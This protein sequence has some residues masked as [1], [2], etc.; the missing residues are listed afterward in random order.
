MSVLYLL[1]TTTLSHVKYQHVHVLRH[2]DAC[3][4][5]E[6]GNLVG[7]STVVVE[8]VMEGW[9]NRLKR[10]KTPEAIAQ[11]SLFLAR[12]VMMLAEFE[13]YPVSVE[14]VLR[15]DTLRKLKLNIGRNDLR[16]A[17]LALELGATVV[18]DNIR[19][20]GRVPGLL[21]VDWTG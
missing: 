12:A 3:T 10:S 1:D 4:D 15:Y 18:T 16:L 8:E 5:P 21:W 17:A 7:I 14:A 19:D 13:L 20:F 2:L 6:S 9:M 11:S